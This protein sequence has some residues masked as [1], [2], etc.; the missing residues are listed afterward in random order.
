MRKWV[1]VEGMLPKSNE[2]TNRSKTLISRELNIIMI[3]SA[4]SM[5]CGTA[6]H[7]YLIN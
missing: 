1:I 2:D 7:E 5:S 3:I 6:A 4:A